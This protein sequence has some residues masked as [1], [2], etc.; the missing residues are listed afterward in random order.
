MDLAMALNNSNATPDMTMDAFQ[1][2]KFLRLARLS[3]YDRM[4][5]AVEAY[6]A[7]IHNIWGAITDL[8]IF[9]KVSSRAIA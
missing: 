2:H 6:Y 5:I 8:A 9:H 1:P 4:M 7:Q 3:A